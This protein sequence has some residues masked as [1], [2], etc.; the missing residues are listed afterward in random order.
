MRVSCFPRMFGRWFSFSDMWRQWDRR[1]IEKQPKRQALAAFFSVR[2]RRPRRI[3]RKTIERPVD[4]EGGRLSG[5]TLDAIDQLLVDM[6]ADFV[7]KIRIS[8]RIVKML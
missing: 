4:R 6:I 7:H 2:A 8:L 1:H 3:D 5:F